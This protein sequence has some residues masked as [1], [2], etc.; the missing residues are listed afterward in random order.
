M[1]P[2]TNF[3]ASNGRALLLGESVVTRVRFKKLDKSI[4]LLERY[5]RQLAM[6]VEDVEQ[7]P[8]RHF[9]CGKIACVLVSY[10]HPS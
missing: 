1:R 3:S 4:S 10:I 6:L 8:L 5:L 2:L 7:I 9:F